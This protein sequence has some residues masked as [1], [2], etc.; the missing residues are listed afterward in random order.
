[1]K[2][3][4]LFLIISILII[5]VLINK[6]LFLQKK[7]IPINSKISVGI[8]NIKP[9]FVPQKYNQTDKRWR[10]DFLGDTN[11]KLGSAGCLVSSVAMNLS[12]YGIDI[13]PKKLNN[14][15]CKHEGYTPN[16]WLI[17]N[18]LQEITHNKIYINFPE[19][20]HKSIDELLVNKNPVL[21]K[22]LIRERI[23][24]WVLIVGKYKGQYLIYDP[25]NSLNPIP[26]DKYQSLIYSIRVIRSH[27]G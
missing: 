17:W 20:S 2:T 9:I 4:I 24:H 15:L 13:N 10:N 23:P 14:A 22:I 25:L 7:V 18:K 3:I 26:I 27:H 19:L 1:M 16:G 21:A 12:Y 8:Q 11:E 6:E 5:M